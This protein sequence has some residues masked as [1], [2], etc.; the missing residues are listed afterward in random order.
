MHIHWYTLASHNCTGGSNCRAQKG[1]GPAA[2]KSA[3]KSA[4]KKLK[5]GKG[6]KSIPCTYVLT[7]A[8]VLVI[9]CIRVFFGCGLG[10]PLDFMKNKCSRYVW[11]HNFSI[12]QPILIFFDVLESSGPELSK[13]P[14]II[15]I[16]PETVKLWQQTYQHVENTESQRRRRTLRPN[17]LQS[18]VRR[19]SSGLGSWTAKIGYSRIMGFYWNKS[20]EIC[21]LEKYYLEKRQI[22]MN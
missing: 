1:K 14:K 7:R 21:N 5:K 18:R 20:Q 16:G 17:L 8:F 12:S 4:A 6:K 3:K 10:G 11:S 9:V 22:L 15:K 19:A 2:C 13:T